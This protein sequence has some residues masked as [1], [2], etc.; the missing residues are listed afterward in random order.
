MYLTQH[1]QSWHFL[2]RNFDGFP[3]PFSQAD[4]SC[5]AKKN[6]NLQCIKYNY[7]QQVSLTR[8]KQKKPNEN[9]L[10]LKTN[11]NCFEAKPKWAFSATN[12]ISKELHHKLGH[13]TYI[14]TDTVFLNLSNFSFS[15]PWLNIQDA[16]QKIRKLEFFKFYFFYIMEYV[17]M[18]HD[19]VRVRT[20]CRN[21]GFQ[22]SV[23]K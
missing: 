21:V 15:L 13:K 5:N 1:H 7:S 14:I 6:K 17:C 16:R 11:I 19:E 9:H 18:C 3:T 2:L 23:L 4:I 12:N 20:Y 10:Q 22:S 8:A